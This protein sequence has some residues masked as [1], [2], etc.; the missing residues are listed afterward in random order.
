MTVSISMSRLRKFVT[1]ADAAFAASREAMEGVRDAKSVVR[2]IEA[3]INPQSDVPGV[4]ESKNWDHVPRS[5]W[6]TDYRK[7][8]EVLAEAE[9]AVERQSE[10][11][12]H[13]G[14]MKTRALEFARLHRIALPADLKGKI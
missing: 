9:A 4:Y 1:E 11:T 6:P 2:A 10:I 13:A 12:Q 3:K 8:R 5:E 14:R 7:A